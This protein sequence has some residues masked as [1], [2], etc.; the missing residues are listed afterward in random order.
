MPHSINLITTIAAAFGLALVFGLIAARLKL[1]PLVGYL[2]AGILIGPHTPGF[3]ADMELAGQLAEIGVMLLMFGVGLHLS[4]DDLMS[5]RKIALP[6]AIVQIA[7]ATLLGM[8]VAPPPHVLAP[9][10]RRTALPSAAALSLHEN[11]I[12]LVVCSCPTKQ[13]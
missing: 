3:V 8:A 13:F 1:P 11:T 4:I 10:R 2:I 12:L 7:V 9:R 6:G 5:V